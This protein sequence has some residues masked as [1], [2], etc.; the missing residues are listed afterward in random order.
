[1]LLKDVYEFGPFRLDPT[2][3]LL[4]R[5]GEL[6]PL[7]PKLFEVLLTLVEDAG[8][9]HDKEELLRRAWPDTHVG[10]N[11]LTKAISA[12]RRVLGEGPAD[13]GYI[14]TAPERGYAF[15]AGV[16]RTSIE[17]D[18]MPASAPA[19][20][21]QT[22]SAGEEHEQ[23]RGARRHARP[24]RS[25]A[26]LP[27]KVLSPE[28]TDRYMGVGLADAL[29]TRLSS[30]K[31]VI[32]RPTSSIVRYDSRNT[33]DDVIGESPG[34]TLVSIGNE[35]GVES[36]LE[37][38]IRRNDD[39]I[40]VTAQ[41]VSV[42][43]GRSLWADKLDQSLTGIFEIEDNISQR[44]A[45]ALALELSGRERS[46]LARHYTED[47]QAYQ[48]YWKGRSAFNREELARALECFGQAIDRDPGFALAHVGLADVYNSYGFIEFL[49]P[50]EAFPKA[51]AAV[52]RALELDD[53]IAEAYTALAVI[54]M[55]YD[56]DFA[57]A[58]Q[59]IDR[60]LTLNPHLAR[61]HQ[62]YARLLCAQG[63][64]ESIPAIDR[65][66]ALD[67]FSKIAKGI[68]GWILY[69]LRRYQ[70]ALTFLESSL[71]QDATSLLVRLALGNCYE[72]LGEGE[73]ATAVCQ[74]A[75][76]AVGLPFVA[77]QL[78]CAYAAAGQ[79]EEA[80]R[81]L[82]Q[83]KER[84]AQVYISPFSIAQIHAALHEPDEVFAWLEIAYQK[85]DPKLVYLRIG[86]RWDWVRE[87]PR[88][89]SLLRRVSGGS[90][91]PAELTDS[92]PVSY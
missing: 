10:Q 27:F 44:I 86:P 79:R 24:S 85:R 69:R 5:N 80:L 1:M 2:R 21:G 6:V 38:S 45:A 76:F 60:A 87:D 18:E 8:K 22:V 42:D 75:G 73:K 46:L 64:D 77:A 52:L 41:L 62:V 50:S 28:P 65:A 32:V 33:A 7:Y 26:V 31:D 53:Q 34:E 23:D 70:E 67:P 20:A 29:I 55:D 3:R 74:Q 81:L 66:L 49:P 40:R 51:R 48:L 58:E 89:A 68:K 47:A 39:R 30:L 78:A 17:D 84:A 61:A 11:S 25:I 12:L 56:W 72:R 35:L 15:V 91:K 71:K 57:E 63:K 82:R 4:S 90:G 88:F 14:L 43:E 59:D 13:H 37:G 83:L 9:V 54:K 16:I 19:P 92:A 36:V